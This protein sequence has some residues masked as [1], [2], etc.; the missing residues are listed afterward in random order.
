MARNFV[1][2]QNK[3]AMFYESGTLGVGSGNAFWVGMVQNHSLSESQG[4]INVRYAGNLSRDVAQFI[5]GPTE[6]SGTLEFYPQDWR[7]LKFAM[8]QVADA[9]SPSPYSHA[10][11]AADSDDE[12]KE[13]AGR[14]L[15][16]FSVEDSQAY[17]AGSN[18]VRTIKGCAIDSLSIST[19]EGAPITCSAEY[20]AQSIAYSS[21]AASAITHADSVGSTTVPFMWQHTKV[22]IPSGTAYSPKN[23]TLTIANNLAV[24]NYVDATRN[25]SDLIPQNRDYNLSLTLN[26]DAQLTKTIYDD[27]WVGGSAFNLIISSIVSLGSRAVYFT[28]SGCK[29]T[30]FDAPTGIEGVNEQT[31]TIVPKTITVAEDSLVQYNNIG[32]FS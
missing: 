14:V 13:I 3:I 6:F 12:C 18:F 4:V 28:C 31:L 15:P 11:T 27:Y 24:P 22:Q 23:V 8:G 16:T 9:G 30:A 20:K 26:G 21:G 1:A 5:D 29:L 32:S 10:Y 19:S 2:D 17:T 25:I 7:M